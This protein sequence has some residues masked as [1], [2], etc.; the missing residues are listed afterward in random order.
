MSRGNLKAHRPVSSAGVQLPAARSD[1]GRGLEQPNR[2]AP[3]MTLETSVRARDDRS[4][5]HSALGVP[6]N[7]RNLIMNTTVPVA[8][9]ASATALASSSALA[10]T[11]T[12]MD[13]AAALRRLEQMIDTLRTC[14]VCDGWHPN[15][16]DE[17]GANRA[18]AYFRAG[19]PEESD[20]DFAE[21]GA[22]FDFISSHG[23]SLDWII[24]G[25]P[26]GLICRAA[27][28][29][30]RAQSL[31]PPD[32]IFA[33]M[34]EH[35]RLDGMQYDLWE[36]LQQIEVWGQTETDLEAERCRICDAAD[37]VGWELTK[38]RPTTARGAGALI[39]YVRGDLNSGK[40][41]SAACCNALEALAGMGSAA[42]PCSVPMLLPTQEPTKIGKL[43]AEWEAVRRE[44]K[45]ANR[46]R[47]KLQASL[48]AGCQ[49]R[50]HQSFIARKMRSTG[51]AIAGR[52]NASPIRCIATSG[53]VTSS[54]R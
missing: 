28:H 24:C 52:P 7:R 31:A 45:A 54:T 50:T 16:L 47:T 25:E 11:D 53:R 9:L 10:P 41:Q 46:V 40:W 33:A 4:P 1:T 51:C 15:G 32:P 48:S 8:S 26:G 2:R 6:V 43:F 13:A 34:A 37:Q 20:K 21:R 39:T 17:A 18:L 14:A 42:L 36:R 12:G 44:Y 35:R 5:A 19:C 38:I 3:H 30:T 29:S 49:N 23:Q 27:K 22:A